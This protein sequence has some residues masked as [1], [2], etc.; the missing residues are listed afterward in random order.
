[1]ITEQDFH[2]GA[3]IVL[4]TARAI[5]DSRRTLAIL[6]EAYL[7]SGFTDME[8]V[9]AEH[10]GDETRE[11]RLA[12]VIREPVQPRLGIRALRALDM[13]D[14]ESFEVD[15]QRLVYELTL[16]VSSSAA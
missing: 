4:E 1:V 15:V 13:T 16:P 8:T 14:D 5:Q 3:P 11:R 12:A 10:L 7:D 9:L 6:T 2:L